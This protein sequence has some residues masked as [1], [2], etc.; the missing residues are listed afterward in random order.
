MLPLLVLL[1]WLPGVSAPYQFDDY[2]TPVGDPAS[3]SLTAWWDAMPQ[4]LRPLTK[5]SYALE[6]SLGARS[7]PSRRLFNAVIFGVCAALVNAL[8]RKAGASRPLAMLLATAWALHPVHAESIVALA[9]RPVLLCLCFTLTSAW[10]LLSARPWLAL[11]AALLALLCRESALPWLVACS[12]LSARALGM[13]HRRVWGL[14][15]SAT[16]VGLICIFSV[17]TLRQLLLSSLGA[18]GAVNR[19]GLQWAALSRGTAALFFDPASFTLDMDFA[20]SGGLRLLLIVVTL[21]LYL[22]AGWLVLRRGS[23]PPVR[24]AALLWLCLVIPTHSVVAKV[25]PFTARPFSASSAA[26][27]VLLGAALKA[28]D[29]HAR[30]AAFPTPLL[31]ACAVAAL[32]GLGAATFARASLYQ[33]PVALWRDAS[34]RS[35][36]S[37]RPLINLGTLLAQRG[38]LRESEAALETALRRDPSSLEIR[39]RLGTVRR[40]E[41]LSHSNHSRTHNPHLDLTAP[42]DL[43]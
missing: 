19:L 31:G 22:G 4:T 9:G 15:V 10:L 27:F 13:S 30:R 1:A 34:E 32:L 38:S 25:D 24:I 28:L 6:S 3:Q 20:P 2:N 17:R 43:P 16:S 39:A 29:A 5:L 21:G 12:V 7:A 37:T 23:S 18:P 42:G 8:G 26:L 35:T 36:H 14:A 41:G 33:D 40:L 11:G